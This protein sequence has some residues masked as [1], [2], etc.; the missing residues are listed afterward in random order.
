MCFVE[1]IMVVR[2]YPPLE[3]LSLK[4]LK[5][6][7]TMVIKQLFKWL[8]QNR[9]LYKLTSENAGHLNNNIQILKV[10]TN[11]EIH[12]WTSN[13]KKKNKT[14]KNDSE[15]ENNHGKENMTNLEKSQRKQECTN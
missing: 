6:L 2:S 13:W 1:L 7:Y 12:G 9:E 4:N 5:K 11:F 8:Y 15:M 14:K 10:E 3:D